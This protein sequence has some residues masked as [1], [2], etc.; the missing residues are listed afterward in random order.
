MA[1]IGPSVVRTAIWDKIEPNLGRY[2]GTD[3]GDAYDRGVT[4]MLKAGR[5]HSLAPEDMAATIWEALTAANPKLRYAPA[6][7]PLVEQVLL[8]AAPRR[9]LDWAFGRI[10]G[11]TRKAGADSRSR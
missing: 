11:L 5:K 2:R 6:N 3:Y 4:I 8:T 10:L 9:L 1:I 7:P